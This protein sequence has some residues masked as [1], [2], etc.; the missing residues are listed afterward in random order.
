VAGAAGFSWQEP[1]GFKIK[2]KVKILPENI[3]HQE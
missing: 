1:V 3:H 2:E